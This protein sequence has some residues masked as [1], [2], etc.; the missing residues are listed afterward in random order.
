MRISLAL[1]CLW[2]A[3]LCAS[4]SALASA[5]F[6]SAPVIDV[7]PP[8]IGRSGGSIRFTESDHIAFLTSP[9]SGLPSTG[10][11]SFTLR[12]EVRSAAVDHFSQIL[13]YEVPTLEL[14]S[15]TAPISVYTS[16]TQLRTSLH[17]ASRTPSLNLT[18][19]A[20]AA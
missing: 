9:L 16:G 10:L 4:A 18:C 19:S 11:T 6:P 13:M 8:A 7:S 1:L 14:V 2:V 15:N 5:L 20:V 3:P 17:T 12:F